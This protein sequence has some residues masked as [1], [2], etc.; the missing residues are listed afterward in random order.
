MFIAASRPRPGPRC[1]PPGRARH[2]GQTPRTGPSGYG[3]DAASGSGRPSGLRPRGLA[4][5][6]AGRRPGPGR[7]RAAL[8]V[9][10]RLL[11]RFHDPGGPGL[12]LRGGQRELSGRRGPAPRGAGQALRGR[13]VGRG[14]LPAAHPAQPGCGLRGPDR[15]LRGLVRLPPSGPGF[16]EG[17]LRALPRRVRRGDPRF[18]GFPRPDASAAWRGGPAPSE[19]KYESIVESLPDI[20]YRLDGEGRIVFINGAVRPTA[21]S[22]PNSRARP[23][24]TWCTPTTASAPAAGSTNAAPAS[25]VP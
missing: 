18:G 9:H 16:L 23:C 8:P 24:S 25:A 10:R 21:T 1:A 20:V 12:S 3:Q 17:H 6:S 19:S 15:E 14:G 2:T 7:R 13:H 5:T 4:R 22:P 11:A